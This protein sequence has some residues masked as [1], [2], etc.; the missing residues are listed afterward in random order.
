[1]RG[2]FLTL[3]GGTLG[4]GICLPF[5]GGVG[6]EKWNKEKGGKYECEGDSPGIA[7]YQSHQGLLPF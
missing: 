3:C 4:F 1:M 6:C 7:I 5:L 2:S